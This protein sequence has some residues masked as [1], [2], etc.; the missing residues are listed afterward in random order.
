MRSRVRVAMIG[1]GR[2]GT[3]VHLAT[4]AERDGVDIVA[5][6]DPHA[7]DL[8]FMAEQH[9]IAHTYRDAYALLDEV[10]DLDAV[11]VVTP[12]DT[13][14][15]IC[16]AAFHRGLHVF[17]EKPLAY[18]VAQAREMAD[19]AR[20]NGLITKMGFNF[21]YSPVI[22]RMKQLIDGGSIGKLHL[23]ESLTVNHQF[24][25]PER[26]RHWKME[27]ARANGGVFVE[28]GCHSID[29]AL[30]L[31]GPITRVVAHGMTLIPERPLEEG[32][33]GPV[34]ADDAASWIAVYERGG[35]ALFRTGWASVPIG[36]GGLRVYGSRGS[37]AWQLDPT[38]RRSE[39]LLARTVEDPEPRV[40]LEFAPSF[41]ARFDE[42]PYP[43]GLIA[44]YSARLME[45]FLSDLRQG[46]PSSPDF[47]D[48][49]AAQH[50]LAAIRTSLDEGRWAK[51]ERG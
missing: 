44:R 21:R 48:G 8:R 49:L 6:A 14:R 47:E 33:R 32:G 37:M 9:G 24:I 10:R 51:V 26:P 17:C 43:I 13:H 25:D 4:L 30:W 40:L 31:G 2:W 45:A 46:R 20:A 38:T 7:P 36:G 15:D 12:T 50:V 18:D 23:F 3:R 11:V 42:P 1:M 5:I 22:Q 28:Y 19:A 34:D 27:R 41:D 39:K 35:E 29:L 16:L